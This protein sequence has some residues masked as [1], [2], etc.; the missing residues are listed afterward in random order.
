VIR[1]AAIVTR[2]SQA[3]A[4]ARASRPDLPPELDALL[5]PRARSQFDQ[6]PAFDQAHSIAVALELASTAGDD[7]LVV[8]GL[9]H[10][11]GKAAP[12]GAVRLVDRVANAIL[13]KRVIDRLVRL[14]RLHSLTVGLEALHR[15]A[16]TGGRLVMDWGY[17]ERVAWLVRHH[18]DSPPTDP[19]LARLV[20]ADARC[21]TIPTH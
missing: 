17:P 19:D 3:Y 18:E 13:P 6:L 2:L 4:H 12:G 9:L 20:E 1:P 7:T 11:I 16:E 8:A 14:P 15:H 21:I 5:K 10:D